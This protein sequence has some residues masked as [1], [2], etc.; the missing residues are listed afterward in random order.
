MSGF[1][2]KDG[3]VVDALPRR[4]YSGLR[5]PERLPL[6][7]T[8]HDGEELPAWLT[9]EGSSRLGKEIEISSPEGTGDLAVRCGTEHWLLSSAAMDEVRQASTIKGQRL[10]LIT[11]L[12]GADRQVERRTTPAGNRARMTGVAPCGRATCPNCAKRLRLTRSIEVEGLLRNLV[13]AGLHPYM[14][15][16]TVR[17][18]GGQKLADTHARLQAGFAKLWTGRFGGRLRMGGLR[19]M[20]TSLEVTYGGN[21]W[22]PHIH[23][24]LASDHHP[25]SR[26]AP[27]DL[28]SAADTLFAEMA[29]RWADAVE[30]DSPTAALWVRAHGFDVEPV[31]H[32]T[33]GETAEYVSGVSLRGA[34]MEATRVDLKSSRKGNVSVWQLPTLM[35]EARRHGSAEVDG[36]AMTLRQLRNLWRVWETTMCGKQQ[37]AFQRAAAAYRPAP[38]EVKKREAELRQAAADQH[39][40]AGWQVIYKLTEDECNLMRCYGVVAVLAAAAADG[41][42]GVAGVLAEYARRRQEASSER[43]FQR[44]ACPPAA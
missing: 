39:D 24:L 6:I 13:A 3:Q 19:L 20:L 43:S 35:V 22:H 25:S 42:T 37:L 7:T 8:G 44:R 12:P 23:A 11:A 2:T 31:R 18:G 21:G 30:P 9:S 4:V 14:V 28:L 29:C 10:C 38:A 41:A 5:L 33:L 15:T 16:L 17:H 40:R 34:A 36:R 26:E 32:H 1:A 27:G